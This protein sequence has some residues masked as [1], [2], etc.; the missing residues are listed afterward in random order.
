M[1]EVTPPVDLA[2]TGRVHRSV[3]LVVGRARSA[4]QR[5]PWIFDGLLVLLAALLSVIPDIFWPPGP[6][7]AWLFDLLLVT[8]LAVRRRWPV[9]VFALIGVVALVQWLTGTL[10]Q[11]DLAVLIALYTVG[12]Y[13]YRLRLIVLT[14]AAAEVGV[15]L[16]TLRWAP[17]GHGLTTALL[18]TGTVTA[19]WVAGVYVRLRREYLAAVVD[20]AVTAERERDSRAQLAVA[21]ERARIAREM[22][23]VVAHSLSVMIALND[24]AAATVLQDP[25]E[26]RVVNQQASAVGRQSMV[27]MRRLLGV[28]RTGEQAQL[29][30]QP[31]SSELYSLIDQVRAAGLPVE[32]AVS[33]LPDIAPPGAQLAVHRIVQE[34]LTN[35]LKHAPQAAHTLVRL[36]YLPDRIDVEITNEHQ[37]PLSEPDEV[38]VGQGLV[39]MRER[40]AVYGGQVHAGRGTDGSW[41][42]SARLHLDDTA[43][44]R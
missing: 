10:A 42:V 20:R 25:H 2:Y 7:P 26:A 23:D 38:E 14:L 8:P 36:D 28:L 6:Q 12:V 9:G 11:G 18:L 1:A 16:A 30:P 4:A 3:L 39:G 15:V 5:Y 43:A 32:L 33:G 37:T 13:E 29:L 34:S 35:V 22:H 19:A 41:R 44:R 31:G 27:E 17:I 21:A 24:G 40:A